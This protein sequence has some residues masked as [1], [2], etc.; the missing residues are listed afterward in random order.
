MLRIQLIGHLGTDVE[1]RYAQKGAPIATA[2]VAVDQVHTTPS[3]ERQETAECFTVRVPG[4]Q[5]EFAQRLG[6]GTRVFVDGRLSISHYT[7]RDGEQRVGFDVWADDIQ[8]L[9]P[10]AVSVESESLGNEGSRA[11]ATDPGD[12]Q[13]DDLPF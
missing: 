6:K 2:R 5:S 4:R 7:S 10:R 13:L 12:D 3:G 8:S 11:G 9:S 1:I